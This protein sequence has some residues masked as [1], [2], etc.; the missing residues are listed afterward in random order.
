MADSESATIDRPAMP[1]PIVRTISS[2][3]SAISIAS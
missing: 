2:S 3:C 1:Q